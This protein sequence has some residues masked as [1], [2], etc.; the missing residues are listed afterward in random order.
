MPAKKNDAVLEMSHDNGL[1]GDA[2]L[3]ATSDSHTVERFK[4]KIGKDFDQKFEINISQ[5]PDQS[6]IVTNCRMGDL[7]HA[8]FMSYDNGF[9]ADYRGDEK[10]LGFEILVSELMMKMP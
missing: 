4:F 10:S 5:S 7:D 6:G 3:P 8:H 2:H 1:G 9:S